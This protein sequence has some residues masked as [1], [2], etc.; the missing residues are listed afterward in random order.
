[1][2]VD[3]YQHGSVEVGIGYYRPFPKGTRMF[4]VNLGHWTLELHWGG[5]RTV[6]GG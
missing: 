3:W 5:P 4:S 6:W 1:M 2:K